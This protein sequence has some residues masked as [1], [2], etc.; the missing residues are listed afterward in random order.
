[1]KAIAPWVRWVYRAGFD[2][3]TLDFLKAGNW[4][5]LTDSFIYLDT[6]RLVVAQKR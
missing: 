5:I 3:R 6:I 2:R 4:E 1:M